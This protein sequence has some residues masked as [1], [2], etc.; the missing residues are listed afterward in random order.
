[1]K[2]ANQLQLKKNPTY[3]IKP[4]KINLHSQ[5]NESI[6]KMSIKK[7]ICRNK[8]NFKKFLNFHK[9]SKQSNLVYCF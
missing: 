1:M 8:Y 5:Q 9:A 7:K 2:E 4:N 3:Y 6:K